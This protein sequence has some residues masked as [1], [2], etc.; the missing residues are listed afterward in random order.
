MPPPVVERRVV[1]AIDDHSHAFP[2]S[3]YLDIM[4]MA[5]DLHEYRHCFHAIV[6]RY[7]ELAQRCKHLREGLH[8]A[9]LERRTAEREILL[10]Q[11]QLQPTVSRLR[12]GRTW[13][14]DGLR[15]EC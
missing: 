7:M 14:S 8:Q 10:L 3:L 9:Q 6:P 2:E 15:R 5:R 12:S 13:R 4:N 1:D 11:E